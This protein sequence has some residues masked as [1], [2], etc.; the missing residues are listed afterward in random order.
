[1]GFCSSENIRIVMKRYI[2]FF[3]TRLRFCFLVMLVTNQI[4]F[5]SKKSIIEKSNLGANGGRWAN[6]KISPKAYGFF[7]LQHRLQEIGREISY[8]VCIQP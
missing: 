3:E 4:D 5:K 7:L 1:M 2:Y 8:S 6:V